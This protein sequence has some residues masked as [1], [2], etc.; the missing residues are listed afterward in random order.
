[1]RRIILTVLAVVCCTIL[2]AKEPKQP[3]SFNYNRALALI[4]EENWEE[5]IKYLKKELN[6]NPKCGYPQ[7]YLAYAYAQLE[8]RG[9]VLSYAEQAVKYLPKA[10][11]YRTA[12]AYRL[13]GVMYLEM[14]DTLKGLEYFNQAVKTDPQ[15]ESWYESRGILYREMKRWAE[16]D[17]DFEKFISLTPGLIRG[18]ILLGHNLYLQERYEEGLDKYKHAHQLAERSFT[19]SGMAECEVKMGKY[20]EAAEHII[21]ALQMKPGEETATRILS[22]CKDEEF[23]SLM[24]T[25]LRIQVRVNPSDV[26]WYIY[27]VIMA[28]SQNN[29]EEAIQIT[30]KIHTIDADSKYDSWTSGYYQD[31][32]DLE[33]ALEY[34]NL[35][36]EDDT[37]N[38]FNLARRAMIYYDLNWQ[39]TALAA[40]NDIIERKPNQAEYYFHRARQYRILGNLPKAL[41]DYETALTLKP[42]NEDFRYAY[43]RCLE[44]LG[45]SAKAHKEYVRLEEADPNAN[46]RVFVLTSLG[47]KD[48]AMHI[49]DSIL[50]SDSSKVALYNMTCVYALLGENDLALATLERDMKNGDVS[51]THMK[52]DYDLVNI[53]GEALNQLIDKYRTIANERIA[54][55]QQTEGEQQVKERVVEIPF[56]AAGGVT[57]VDCTING[58]ALNF[59]FDTGASD[60]TIS[61]TEANFMYKNGFLS[62][63]DVVGKQHFITA[64]G[65]IIEGTIFIIR[66]I[67]FGGLELT[68]VQ[69]S[70]V[71]NQKAPLLLGQTVLKRLGKIE[72]DNERRVLKI[73]TK[74]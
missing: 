38:V 63:K 25:K 10:D 12:Y 56:T 70:V 49:A 7:L 65:S 57:K 46:R 15:E 39:D 68:D 64:D 11:K 36:I 44:A 1:M 14:C 31:M 29:Y 37:T 41:E 23:V 69:A 43:A 32:G 28:E 60:V 6:E 62:D 24:T 50:Q 3:D 59:V 16:S 4:E 42:G 40:F 30:K 47:R 45:D 18:Y 51:F 52:M 55:F 73:T 20:E 8:E 2:W 66:K 17:A 35:A 48:E 72:I 21:T 9:N 13:Q 58:L 5:A 22:E 54:R 34:I 71:A 26:N 61:M 53:Q 33:H 74:N 67:N 27:Q 19:C